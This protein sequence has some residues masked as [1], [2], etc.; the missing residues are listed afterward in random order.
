MDHPNIVN[1]KEYFEDNRYLL[2]VM[3]FIEEAFELQKI[4]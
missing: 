4:I 3:E 2:I 1:Y